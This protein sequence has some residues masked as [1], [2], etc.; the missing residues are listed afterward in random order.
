[1]GVCFPPAKKNVYLAP[2]V[3]GGGGA[4]PKVLEAYMG[5][6]VWPHP[7]KTKRHGLHDH[8]P[9]VEGWLPS[10]VRVVVVL[11]RLYDDQLKIG[12]S[13]I[14]VHILSWVTD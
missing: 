3:D 10:M 1:L 5:E 7:P 14:K 9:N 6:V 4:P 12:L 2:I 13:W 11:L 8:W